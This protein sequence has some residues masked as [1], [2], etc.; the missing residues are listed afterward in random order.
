MYKTRFQNHQQDK[1]IH[2]SFRQL[3]AVTVNSLFNFIE[4][5][6]L[7]HFSDDL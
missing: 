6:P 7:L 3:S 1:I 5:N 4:V 2:L